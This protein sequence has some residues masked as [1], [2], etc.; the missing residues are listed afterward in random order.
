MTAWST[1]LTRMRFW[2]GTRSSTVKSYVYPFSLTEI[3]E[4]GSFTGLPLLVVK[5][6][7]LEQEAAVGVVAH[8][9]RKHDPTVRIESEPL[10][11]ETPAVRVQQRVV[12]VLGGPAVGIEID[13]A[14]LD[15]P[16]VG[17]HPQALEDF[18][19]TV[20]VLLPGRLR[21][22]R[23]CD[24][25]RQR[26]HPGH[27]CHHSRLPRAT[28]ACGA[29]TPSMRLSTR[30][31]VEARQM[32]DDISTAAAQTQKAGLADDRPDPPDAG[33]G[34]GRRRPPQGGARACASIR[35]LAGAGRGA[36]TGRGHLRL[37]P[38]AGVPP[39]SRGAHAAGA[40]GDQALGAVGELHPA[41]HGPP[42]RVAAPLAGRRRGGRQS[43]SS[44]SRG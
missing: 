37:R 36:P 13:L 31:I 18:R 38:R 29:Y 41:R 35:G 12:L 2:L 14:D 43:S 8:P 6:P 30:R 17:V 42:P 20:A 23:Q 26:C 21:R 44:S 34:D 1:N 22:G 40:G 5:H 10:V 32:P 11:D 27:P 9:F 39:G 15:G 4:T 33:P 19:S 3:R 16:A 24:H 25:Q 7:V 28:C